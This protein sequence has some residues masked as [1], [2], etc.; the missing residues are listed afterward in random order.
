MKQVKVTFLFF[1]FIISLNCKNDLKQDNKPLSI[2]NDLI[3]SYKK[4]ISKELNH[5]KRL[6]LS[7][8]AK[9]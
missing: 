5:R 2:K 4:S 1:I 9:K 6:N 3:L 7:T 8:V